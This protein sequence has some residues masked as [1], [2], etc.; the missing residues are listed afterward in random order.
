M[1]SANQQ[2]LFCFAGVYKWAL[3]VCRHEIKKKK[4]T[5]KYTV[6]IVAKYHLLHKNSTEISYKTNETEAENEED[7]KKTK[8]RE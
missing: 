4:N 6:C 8:K 1:F 3:N 5:A 7:E 2:S